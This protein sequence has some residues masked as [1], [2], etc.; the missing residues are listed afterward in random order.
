MHGGCCAWCICD[1]P[2]LG[3]WLSS[4]VGKK[5]HLFDAL[6]AG[7][8][9]RPRVIVADD[10]VSEWEEPASRRYMRR[11]GTMENFVK[12]RRE[13]GVLF[14]SDIAVLFVLKGVEF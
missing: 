3:N 2:G 4:C 1:L 12:R 10:Y 6:F 5:N 7:I 14:T 9:H 8:K 13:N 11:Y